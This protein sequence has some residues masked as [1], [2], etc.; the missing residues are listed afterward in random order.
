MLAARSE[1]KLTEVQEK[2]IKDGG[3][4]IS[5]PTDITNQED[6]KNLIDAA[7]NKFGAV[8]C[9]LNSAYRPGNFTEF[10]D[11][12]L[13]DWKETMNTNFF[14]TLGLTKV[15]VEQMKKQQKGSIV[16]INSLITKNPFPLRAAML[17]Q[18][19]RLPVLPRFLP[20]S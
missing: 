20:R 17:L 11:S 9:L 13:E 5:V 2:I 6:C 7:V 1:D 4:A 8:D 3:K 16:M 18:R 15:A 19:V 12:D 14:G 10:L